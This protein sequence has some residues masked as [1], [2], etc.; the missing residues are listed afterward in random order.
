MI[1]ILICRSEGAPVGREN[2]R[3][4]PGRG[5]LLSQQMIRIECRPFAARFGANTSRS[6][7][8]AH[9]LP[10]TIGYMLLNGIR[11]CL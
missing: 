10:V 4:P 5:L 1:L 8:F 6:P 3:P 11:S 2:H 7:P 9:A